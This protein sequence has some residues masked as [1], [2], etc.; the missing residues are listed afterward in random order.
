[1]RARVTTL[2]RRAR[3]QAR[4]LGLS[5]A[6]I[7]K[8][9]ADPRRLALREKRLETVLGF[10]SRRTEVRSAVD[11]RVRPAAPPR[12]RTL[13]S[14]VRRQHSLAVRRS[15]ALG[16]DRPAP[17]RL[18][19]TGEGRRAQL[20]HWRSVAR[21]LRARTERVRPEERPLSARLRHY[22]ALTCIASHESNGTW[23]ISTGNGYYGGLQMDRTFQQTYAP[24]LYRT[25]G[26][27]DNWTRAEQ[28]RTAEKAV[29]TRGFHPWPNTARMCGLI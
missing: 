9:P 12:G 10:L 18:A 14:R 3:A 26:T 4:R 6:S 27:A 24:D 13:S 25:K 17:L 28:M 7:A 19:A 15:I 11:E 23:D 21:W 2:T 1:M 22:D 29:A 16:V 5:P 20:S 8:V